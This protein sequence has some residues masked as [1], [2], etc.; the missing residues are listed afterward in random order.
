MKKIDLNKT[1]YDLVKEYPEVINIMV[2]LGFAEITKKAMLNSMGKIMTIPRGAKVH[3]I[4]IE[5]IV[6]KFEENGFEV[7]NY[8]SDVKPK[9]KI[10][11]ENLNSD[12]P[13]ARTI[14]LKSYLKRLGE[15]EDLE[16]VRRDFKENFENID[17][18]EIMHAEQSMLAEGTPLSEV[19]RLCDLHSALFHGATIE[20]QIQNAEKSIQNKKIDNDKTFDRTKFDNKQLVTKKLTEKVGHPLNTFAAENKKLEEL[21]EETKIA[22]EKNENV[23]EA[24]LNLRDISIHYAKKGDLLYP[25]L[26][27]KYNISGPSKVM[28]TVDDEIRA[29]MRQLLSD[30][31]NAENNIDRFKALLKRIE[32]MI[33]KEENIL[34]PNCA[35]NFTEDEWKHLYKDM[36]DYESVFGLVPETWQE[37]EDFEDIEY[38]VLDNKEINLLGGHVNLNELNS[39]LNTIPL[40]L[41]FVDKNNINKYFNDGEKIMKRPKMAID[42]EVFSCHPPKIQPLVKSIIE[43]LRSGRKD[44][45]PVWLEKAG[46]PVFINYIAVRDEDGEYV[47]VLETVQDMS[48]A[49]EYFLNPDK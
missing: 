46:R 12:T 5:D 23:Y 29:E 47:G 36:K 44:N 17:A 49:K 48:F 27:A 9:G 11:E 35:M 20:E 32:E 45:V 21:I 4:S 25:H 7:I 43:D 40:E 24:F 6:K 2:E 33:Y 30:K 1:V 38:K 13:E 37:A 18:Q 10:S 42:R 3:D 19:Q 39:L 34:F 16:S 22:L 14:L 26:E 15:G 31:E 28:W 8:S 41:T